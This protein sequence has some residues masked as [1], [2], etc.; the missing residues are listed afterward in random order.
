[1]SPFFQE[2]A[3]LPTEVLE[4]VEGRADNAA[5][6]GL[7][8]PTPLGWVFAGTA[9][10]YLDASGRAYVEPP[11]GPVALWAGD[12]AE[13]LERLFFGDALKASS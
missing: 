5:V 9:V 12:V 2:V 6:A 1:M 3:F 8:A 4:F 10:L 7:D 13:A 11:R